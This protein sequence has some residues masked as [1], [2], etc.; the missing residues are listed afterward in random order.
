MLYL[1]AIIEP[2]SA[3]IALPPGFGDIAPDIVPSGQFSLVTGTLAEAPRREEAAIRR[4][5][6][7]LEALMPQCN[8]L[9]VRFGTVF[10][11]REDLV[12]SITG[13]TASILADLKHLRGQLELG[14]TVT[15][16]GAPPVPA[17]APRNADIDASSDAPGPGLRYIASKRA[18]HEQRQCEMRENE[19]LAERTCAPFLPLV[20]R[21][22]WRA[23]PALAG[24]GVSIA[25]L[26]PAERLEAFRL[27]LADLLLAAPDLK[28]L[29]T[30][31]WPPF[32]YVGDGARAR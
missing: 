15:V 8:L 13:M 29:C 6:D 32:T 26:L 28:I 27:A 18:E 19:D 24:R 5:M 31:P 23:L 22:V 16:R 25:L 20:S 11:T 4:H 17:I 21:H 12:R 10:A 1:Y 2:C 3:P 7:V 30:G 14:L 9:P